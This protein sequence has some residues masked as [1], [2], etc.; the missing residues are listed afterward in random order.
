MTSLSSNP[1]VPRD[2][3]VAGLFELPI[4]VA[5]KNTL[6][7]KTTMNMHKMNNPGFP[8]RS[9]SLKQF[10]V[11]GQP[12]P[13]S[14]APPLYLNQK[15]KRLTPYQLQRRQMQQSFLFPN[16]ESFTPKKDISYLKRSRSE[17]HL[18]M[19]QRQHQHSVPKRTSLMLHQLENRIPHSASFSN[20]KE[21]ENQFPLYSP[22]S[23]QDI[24]IPEIDAGPILESSTSEEI[25]KEGNDEADTVLGGS[26]T[27]TS[28]N[29]TD[30]SIDL[31]LSNERLK[32]LKIS[33]PTKVETTNTN[34]STI[35]RGKSI[36]K[37]RFGSLFK[38]L[39]GNKSSNSNSDQKNPIPANKQQKRPKVQ[40]A[41][42][43]T[44]NEGS[45]CKKTKIVDSTDDYL[46][47]NKISLLQIKDGNFLNDV[48]AAYE[49]N[50]AELLLDI[51][52]VFDNLLLKS[53][54]NSFVNGSPTR[55][56]GVNRINLSMSSPNLT[57][58]RVSS[59]RFPPR[60]K[61]RPQLV[62][63]ESAMSFYKQIDEN[64]SELEEKIITR[65]N[66]QWDSV[67]IDD[68]NTSIF[69]SS[70]ESSRSTTTSG[71]SK[72]Q[73]AFRFAN[74]IHVSNTWSAIEYERSDPKFRY[75]H[76]RLLQS[77]NRQE[78]SKVKYELNCYKKNEMVVNQYSI[79]NTHFFP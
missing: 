17:Q 57:K 46:F 22:V 63:K 9:H 8:P 2:T 61:H 1:T 76:R 67:Q 47:D 26:A 40:K 73:K 20:F 78:L 16:G 45:P 15:Q 11:M 59:P 25:L 70:L 49:N 4:E 79:Q 58:Q 14:F 37:L 13:R 10:P 29:D 62:T 75:N 48:T 6:K 51:D 5:R 33:S 28:S 56:E 53:T 35:K 12:E 19:A 34:T 41:S 31:N 3:S 27:T 18:P 65:L 30:Y 52:L 21:L 32:K 77:N 23:K 60:S 69:D 74:E 68:P 39:W 66:R 36:S 38:K 43:P 72:I 54:S 7:K 24:E 44:Q 55:E 50:N 64:V 42:S 71:D